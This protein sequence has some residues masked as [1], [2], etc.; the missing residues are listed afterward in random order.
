MDKPDSRYNNYL[1]RPKDPEDTPM[2]GVDVEPHSDSISDGTGHE[3]IDFLLYLKGQGKT[4]QELGKDAV[5]RIDPTSIPIVD[6]SIGISYPDGHNYIFGNNEAQQLLA[7]FDSLITQHKKSDVAASLHQEFINVFGDQIGWGRDLAALIRLCIRWGGVHLQSRL[8]NFQQHIYLGSSSRHTQDMKTLVDQR[9]AETNDNLHN[10]SLCEDIE[11]VSA[12]NLDPSKE[13]YQDTQGYTESAFEN[14]FRIRIPEAKRLLQLG[15]DQYSTTIRR[16]TWWA[17]EVID[18]YINWRHQALE[19]LS[20]RKDLPA[21][22]RALY[23]ESDPRIDYRRSIWRNRGGAKCDTA[24]EDFLYHLFKFVKSSTDGTT[25]PDQYEAW[26]SEAT[27]FSNTMYDTIINKPQGMVPCFHDDGDD[28]NRGMTSYMRILYGHEGITRN[29]P[30][31]QDTEIRTPAADLEEEITLT[32]PR[33]SVISEETDSLYIY[34]YDRREHSADVENRGNKVESRPEDGGSRNEGPRNEGP[35]RGSS[36]GSSSRGSRRRQIM[37]MPSWRRDPNLHS[38]GGTAKAAQEV[39]IRPELDS[40]SEEESEEYSFDLPGP[41]SHKTLDMILAEQTNSAGAS[42]P[43]P[44]LSFWGPNVPDS[45]K[46]PL[47]VPAKRKASAAPVSPAAPIKRP[48]G[49]RSIAT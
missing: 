44:A 33:K 16:R 32:W 27:R 11:W 9:L 3:K 12:L 5:R 7:E 49:S 20:R 45:T 38:D 34:D 1:K 40:F 17:I 42:M 31:F 14:I 43:T 24:Y 13:L 39:Q 18:A 2:G 35:R 10:M 19:Y 28:I 46:T 8:R 4:A 48:R 15:S 6:N 29:F 37:S 41:R 23:G 22:W 30:Q 25:L 36:Q 21:N 26:D 47:K